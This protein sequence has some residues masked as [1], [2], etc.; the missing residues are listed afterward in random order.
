LS[1]ESTNNKNYG[2]IHKFFELKRSFYCVIQ[3]FKTERLK[4]FANSNMEKKNAALKLNSFFKKYFITDKFEL[5]RFEFVETKCITFSL[6]NE[7]CNYLTPCVDLN[8][9]D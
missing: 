5:V 3:A 6:Q 1:N 9:H 7:N 8:E 2:I 4:N